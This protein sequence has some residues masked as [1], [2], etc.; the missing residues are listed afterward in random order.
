[1]SRSA[2]PVA[3]LP[4]LYSGPSG[5]KVDTPE[6]GEL[7]H[8][9]V[10]AA[11]RLNDVRW[12]AAGMITGTT[13]SIP[14][15][16][17]WVM[18]EAEDKD[19]ERVRQMRDSLR[20]EGLKQPLIV[21]PARD[22]RPES[23]GGTGGEYLILDGRYRFWGSFGTRPDL[24]DLECVVQVYDSAFDV[25]YSALVM[26]A[27]QRELTDEQAGRWLRRLRA[28][29]EGAKRGMPGLEWPKQIEWA[30]ILGRDQSTVSRWLGIAGMHP[31][32]RQAVDDG[33]LSEAA[34][35]ELLP[36]AHAAQRDV[37]EH[38][39]EEA[40]RNG[41]PTVPQKR[42]RD[43]VQ[44]RRRGPVQWVDAAEIEMPTDLMLPD[45][46][47]EQ[48]LV[49][50]AV[51]AHDSIKLLGAATAAMKAAGQQV[52]PALVAWQRALMSPSIAEF[53]TQMRETME[54]GSRPE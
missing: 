5:S 35:V 45:L 12:G 54:G 22:P 18:W 19:S 43:L 1:M 29:Y 31:E 36:L 4:A 34:A 21:V 42:A 8:R 51:L 47:E 28:I 6:G 23:E 24:E 49:A 16:R 20:L 48:P 3:G 32:V 14:R 7:R 17:L 33:R 44:Q 26:K 40:Q 46:A 38:L 41:T 10:Q 25:F 39:I 2:A 11:E 15:S 30:R 37:A 53:V 27:S 52:H 9:I 50:L 13:Q